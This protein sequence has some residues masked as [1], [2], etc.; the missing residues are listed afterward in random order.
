MLRTSVDS[1]GLTNPSTSWLRT[2]LTG[3]AVAVAMTSPAAAYDPEEARYEYN[4]SCH[5]TVF[6]K[7]ENS[8]LTFRKCKARTSDD[9]QV[10]K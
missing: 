2:M 4:E 1:A 3:A 8:A 9:E 6:P 7:N 5:V 10:K